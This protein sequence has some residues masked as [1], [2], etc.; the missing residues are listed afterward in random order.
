MGLATFKRSFGRQLY[1]EADFTDDLGLGWGLQGF[2]SSGTL[3][4]AELST[5]TLQEG[6]MG[7]GGLT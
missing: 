7:W 2:L 1:C 5:G 4:K 6:W 3:E